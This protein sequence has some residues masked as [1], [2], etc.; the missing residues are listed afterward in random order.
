MYSVVTY[1]S[2]MQPHRCAAVLYDED[3][4]KVALIHLTPPGILP[5]QALAGIVRRALRRARR[6]DLDTDEVLR[7]LSDRMGYH[8]VSVTRGFAGRLEAEASLLTV[9]GSRW[10]T[11]ERL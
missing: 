8:I 6:Q 10:M 1:R 11:R 4:R 9:P 5:M 2:C 3:A 7:L